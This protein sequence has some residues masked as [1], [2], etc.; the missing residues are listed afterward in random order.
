ML[1]TISGRPCLA[2]LDV[3]IFQSVI[4]RS[5]IRAANIGN[6]HCDVVVATVNFGLSNFGY[7]LPLDFI[8]LDELPGYDVIFGLEFQQRC[9]SSDCHWIF[10]NLPF[11]QSSLEGRIPLSFL[12]PLTIQHPVNIQSV[13]STNQRTVVDPITSAQDVAPSYPSSSHTFIP[14][15]SPVVNKLGLSSTASSTLSDS[16]SESSSSQFI[17]LAHFLYSITQDT[18]KMNHVWEVCWFRKEQV[19]EIWLARMGTSLIMGPIV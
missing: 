18:Q 9:Q 14:Q 3:T 4:S 6:W 17:S 19:P 12:P 15:D 5:F 13:G 16:Q 1:L 10:D 11:V 7:T 8:V 2:G